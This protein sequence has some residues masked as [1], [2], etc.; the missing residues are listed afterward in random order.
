MLWQG[1]EKAPFAWLMPRKTPGCNVLASHDLVAHAR[2][3]WR[4]SSKTN[5][6]IFW[7][8][9][10]IAGSL[11]WYWA[12]NS[13]FDSQHLHE[14]VICHHGQSLGLFGNDKPSTIS[15]YFPE[16]WKLTCLTG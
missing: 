15:N 9:Q 8:D 10:E 11:D 13:P 3:L 14:E 6:K 7:N 1:Q 4:M 12:I 5:I 16:L 2:Y